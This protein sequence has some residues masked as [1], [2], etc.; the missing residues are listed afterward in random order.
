VEI[1]P[2]VLGG[3]PVVRGTRV[4]ADTI[5]Q[6][7]ELGSSIEEIHQNFPSLPISTIKQLIKFVPVHA[8]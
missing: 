8:I 5:I 7:Y 2:D 4:A 3:A 6:D 1:D